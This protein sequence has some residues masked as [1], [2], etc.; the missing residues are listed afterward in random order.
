[1]AFFF[2]YSGILLRCIFGTLPFYV[3]FAIVEA[4]KMSF[5][6]V[7]GVSN[8]STAVQLSIILN[9]DWVQ[10]YED[11]TIVKGSLVCILL[12]LL[13]HLIEYVLVRS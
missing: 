11:K 12:H 10:K 4:M 6:L 5:T 9:Y 13:F 8:V 2:F 7:T 1:M 3:I